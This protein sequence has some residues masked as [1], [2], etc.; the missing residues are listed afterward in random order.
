MSCPSDC[1]TKARTQPLAVALKKPFL[2]KAFLTH[3]CPP[4]E[5]TSGRHP[6]WLAGD[7]NSASCLKLKR[8][9]CNFDIYEIYQFL[10]SLLKG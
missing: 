7:S 8:I 10:D 6:L 2:T 1:S 5:I 9:F 4:S 3:L